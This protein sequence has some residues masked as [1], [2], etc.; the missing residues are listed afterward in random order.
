MGTIA[1]K[2]CEFESNAGVCKGLVP[3]GKHAEQTIR[4]LKPGKPILCE[5][6]STRNPAH[7]RKFF[8]VLRKVFEQQEQFPTED[9]LRMATLIK[10]GKFTV[11]TGFD[12]LPFPEPKSM[13]YASMARDEFEEFYDAAIAIWADLIGVT[14][15]ELEQEALREEGVA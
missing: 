8:A 3:L 10:L 5:A 9:A 6:K 2:V 11:H 13:A 7:H 12:G 4:K 1:M 15:I 14:P